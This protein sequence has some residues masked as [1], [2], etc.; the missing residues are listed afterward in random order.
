MN[1][2]HFKHR[3]M[4]AVLKNG[5]RKKNGTVFYFALEDTT[6]GA[7]WGVFLDIPKKMSIFSNFF[8]LKEF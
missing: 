7:H 5:R 3:D 2:D 8:L 4:N 1:G 6:G